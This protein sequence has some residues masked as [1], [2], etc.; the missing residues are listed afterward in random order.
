MT[1]GTTDRVAEHELFAQCSP[2][3]LEIA[4]TLLRTARV[5]AG[6]HLVVEDTVA[7]HLVIVFEGEVSVRRG[8]QELGRLRGPEVVGEAGLVNRGRCTATVVTTTEAVIALVGEPEFRVLDRLPTVG[9][10]LRAAAA[11]R[12]A[13]SSL[14]PALDTS[15]ED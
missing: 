2:F 15:P 13:S 11:A 6:Y 8:G 1:V 4:R 10:Q 14:V 9:P 5:P 12:S 3:E 7:H